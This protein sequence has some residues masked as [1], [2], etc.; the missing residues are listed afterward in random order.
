MEKG[1][2]GR[3]EDQVV[4]VGDGEG[5]EDFQ[6]HRDSKKRKEK[7]KRQKRFTTKARRHKGALRKEKKR[8]HHRGHGE[9]GEK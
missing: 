5:V 9:H 1:S 8:I 2:P 7:N 6:V 4:P 3:V